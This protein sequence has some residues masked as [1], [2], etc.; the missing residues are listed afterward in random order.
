[1]TYDE[2]NK[3][4]LE[5]LKDKPTLLDHYEGQ[6]KEIK[7]LDALEGAGVDNWPGID[8]AKDMMA[9]KE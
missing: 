3:A 6:L 7:W 2:L 4:I 8:F 1:M 5:V 9:G